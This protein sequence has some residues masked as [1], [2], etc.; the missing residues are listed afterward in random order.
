VPQGLPEGTG[1]FDFHAV[2]PPAF[3]IDILLWGK[4]KKNMSLIGTDN[5][6]RTRNDPLLPVMLDFGTTHVDPYGS[7]F[8]L[9]MR[10]RYVGA[11]LDLV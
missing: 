10:Y 4:V 8:R 7:G 11:H 5:G 3:G 1:C 2:Y 9:P 6:Q